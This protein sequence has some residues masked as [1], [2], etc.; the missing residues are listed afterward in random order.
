MAPGRDSTQSSELVLSRPHIVKLLDKHNIGWKLWGTST[1]RTLSDLFAYHERD[2]LYF[3]DTESG[4]VMD[5]HAVVVLVYHRYRR[6]WVELYEDCQIF[7][8][9][10]VLRRINFNGIEETIKRSETLLKAA[11]RCLSEELQFHE[12]SR[13]QLSECIMVEQRD[14]VPSEK[15]PGLYAAYH[16]YIFECVI[17]RSL[18]RSNGYVEPE[19]DRLVYFRWKPRGQMTFLS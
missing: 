10:H 11:R 18:F 2:R 1:S 13:Y 7:P 4:V 9:G 16:R 17:P 14:P 5:V 15:W 8:G 12:P 3:R 6:R 19:N